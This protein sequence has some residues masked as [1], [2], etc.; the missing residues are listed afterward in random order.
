MFHSFQL[1]TQPVC[2]LRQLILSLFPIAKEMNSSL[3]RNIKNIKAKCYKIPENVSTCTYY[4]N[5]STCTS[6]LRVRGMSY[7]ILLFVKEIVQKNYQKNEK[8]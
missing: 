4:C 3:K 1:L 7:C 8:Y 2:L 5:V 6:R